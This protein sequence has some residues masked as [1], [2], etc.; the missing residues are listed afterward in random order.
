M[1]ILEY[2]MPFSVRV[3]GMNSLW[4]ATLLELSLINVCLWSDG[5]LYYHYY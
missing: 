3:P 2:N 5:V 1:Q 4:L